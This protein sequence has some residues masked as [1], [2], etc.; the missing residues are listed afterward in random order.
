M[1]IVVLNGSPKG[2]LSITLHYVRYI[3]Q[4]FPKH[5]L[6]II[7]IAEKIKMIENDDKLFDEIS[8]EI[9]HAKGVLWIFPVYYFL[10]PYQ[11]KRFIELLWERDKKNVFRNKYTAALSTSVHFYDDAAHNYIN[12]I[13][14]DL[15]MKYIGSFS[16]DMY[17]LLKPTERNRL[18]L[19][20]KYFFEGIENNRWTSKDCNPILNNDFNYIAGKG[21]NKIKIDNKNLVVITDS[22]HSNTNL[23]KMVNKFKDLF[24]EEIDVVNLNALNILG[25]CLG[26]LHC[27]FDN[28]CI[29]PQKDD[30]FMHFYNTKVQNADILIFAGTIKDRFLSSRWKL[31]FDRSFFRTHIPSLTKKQIGFIISGPL[32]EIPNLR[33]ILEAYCECSGANLVDIITDEDKDSNY[34]DSLLY[35][36][37]IRLLEFSK[38]NYIKP[39]TFL[40]KGGMKVLRDEIWGRLRVVFHADH[41]FYK[42]RRLYDFPQKDIKMRL[43]NQVMS[44]VI[45]IPNVKKRLAKQIKEEMVKPHKKIIEK[46]IK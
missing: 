28:I 37:A 1:K 9:M 41:K 19:F 4:N 24:L 34:I 26:C 17:D 20:A 30:S 39:I 29:Y 15:D 10:I 12:A 25:G 33:R 36:F 21:K 42:K 32:R 3:Q 38:D 31:F 27:A 35:D 8:L 6:I 43:I 46:K 40:S 44:F 45:K 2:D 16:A 5:E 13:C 14:R 7:N 18:I 23:N 22:N 11:L